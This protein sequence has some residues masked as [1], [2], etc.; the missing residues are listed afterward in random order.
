VIVSANYPTESVFAFREPPVRSLVGNYPYHFHPYMED[1]SIFLII[2]IVILQIRTYFDYNVVRLVWPIYILLT[3][4]SVFRKKKLF[5]VLLQLVGVI[6]LGLSLQ[7][8]LHLNTE[9]RRHNQ[10]G[11]NRP[12]HS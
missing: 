8:R 7:K 6:F 5:V 12:N 3:I 2:Y 1:W 11:N 9:S 4:C 10:K